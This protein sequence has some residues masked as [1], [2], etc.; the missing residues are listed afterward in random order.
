MVQVGSVGE[1]LSD[2]V[3]H[4]ARL[5]VGKRS[6]TA[7]RVRL[8]PQRKFAPA[9]GGLRRPLGGAYGLAMSVIADDNGDYCLELSRLLSHLRFR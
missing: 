8:Q 7:V 5:V 1:D 2:E 9:F 6:C 3:E 4:V